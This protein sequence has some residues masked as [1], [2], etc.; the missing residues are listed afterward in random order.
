MN[1]TAIAWMSSGLILAGGS[2]YLASEALS[3]GEGAGITTTIN[4]ATGETGP[5]GP[6]GPIGPTGTGE[7]GPAG[8]PGPIGPTGETGSQGPPG[9]VGPVGPAGGISCPVGY[10]EGR[11]V[12]NHPG[13]QTAIWTCIAP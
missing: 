5:S 8:P 11:L 2:G 1:K 3:Q 4:V 6:P 13:G 12:I 10:D 7:T 9:P